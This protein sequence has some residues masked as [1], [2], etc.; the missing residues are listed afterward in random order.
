VQKITKIGI[1][2]RYQ[3][4]SLGSSIMQITDLQQEQQI[5][6]LF[7]LGFRPFFLGGALFSVIAIILWLL[8][9]KG[10]LP[11]QPL[12]GGYWWHIH[13]MIFGFASA[14]VAG[15]LLTAVQNWTG[16]RGIY[17]N[18]L[19]AL[20]TVWLLGRVVMLFPD[21]AGNIVSSIIDLSFLP[22]VAILLAQ[23]IIAVKQ[24]RNL[25]F[26]PLLL[27][28]T[29]ANLQMHLA[30]YYPNSV[31]VNFSAYAGVMLIV[32]LMSVMAGRV[33][34]MF[35]ANGTGSEKV[36][37]IK[38]LEIVTNGSI[39]LA[40][41]ALL[42]QPLIG[43]NRTIFGL[44]LITAGFAQA[45]RWLRLRPWITLGVPLLWSFHFAILFVWFGLLILGLSYLQNDVP[46]NHVWHLLT[47]GGIGGIILAM[48]SRVSLGHTGRPL[49]PPKIMSTAFFM[50]SLATLIR[51]FGPLLMPEKSLLFYDIS[52]FCWLI[53]FGSFV[54][55]YGPMLWSARADN[56]PG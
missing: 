13:E 41:F 50:I 39:A 7:R 27:L 51:V 14:I 46:L 21:L 44:I 19:I 43:F 55:K 18:K 35:T 33:L 47:I 2:A 34:P 24:Y 38:A 36:L 1:L 40:M 45:K 8:M 17:G 30:I 15:F 22:F 37:P 53:G 12:G 42:L 20:F 23:P 4:D 29:L 10:K 3:F 49:A 26:I 25:F 6:P 52:G 54:V 11:M 56:R 16:T 48:I 31:A 32:F 9:L 28:F 5:T